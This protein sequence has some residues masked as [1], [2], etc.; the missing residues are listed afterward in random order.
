MLYALDAQEL[1]AMSRRAEFR[2]EFTG[3]EM[4]LAVYRT[5]PAVV[6]RI[7]PRPLKPAPLPLV[8]AFVARYPQTNFGSAYNEGALIVQASF[9]GELGGYCLAM[10]VD[11]DNALIAGRELYGF[12]KKIAE[13]IRID[14]VRNTTVGRVVRKG[15]EIL[16][17]ELEPDAPAD[18]AS[19][20]M[21]G[22]AR[23]DDGGRTCLPLSSYL[24]K[25]FPSPDGR[26]FDYIPRLVR[27]V[28]LFRPRDGLR[29]GRARV[30]VTSSPLDPLGEVPVIGTP[31]ACVHGVW[32]NTMLPGDVVAR[33]WNPRRFLPYAF[34]KH[35]TTVALLRAAA[36]PRAAAP[37][38]QSPL[39]GKVA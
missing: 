22:A 3:A 18:L 28:T 20:A 27:Q 21:L 25:F 14:T 12:P 36:E 30:V 2:S 10:P 19:L 15:T 37:P 4:L 39:P 7:L 17:I 29:R 35:D 9:R 32:D 5:D 31:I 16:R 26:S 11:E 1:Q 38:V 24:F 13:Q 23:P 34:F 6:A 8:L 33:V